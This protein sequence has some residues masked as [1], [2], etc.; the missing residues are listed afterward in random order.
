MR[1]IVPERKRAPSADN[2]HNR[3]RFRP[4]ALFLGVSSNT[5]EPSW[6]VMSMSESR[7]F[8]RYMGLSKAM[9]ENRAD[10]G[11]LA[12]SS[13]YSRTRCKGE[14]NKSLDARAAELN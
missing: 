2:L 6:N 9:V 7:T 4:Y 8:T 12:P 3:V 14:H 10:Q 13:R 5:S 1:L 11:T